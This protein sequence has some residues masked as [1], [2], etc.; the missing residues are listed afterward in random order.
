MIRN[1]V[2]L[3]LVLLLFRRAPAHAHHGQILRALSEV[4]KS[5]DFGSVRKLFTDQAWDCV[6]GGV[7]GRNLRE[8]RK[9]FHRAVLATGASN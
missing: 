3:V 8:S 2:G 9:T 5:G 7:A 1:S 6:G 4:M